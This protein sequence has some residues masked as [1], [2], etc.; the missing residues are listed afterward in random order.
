[1]A[2]EG[3]FHPRNGKTKEKK[4]RKK[5]KKIKKNKR[6]ERNEKGRKGRKCTCA[7]NPKIH[8]LAETKVLQ[9]NMNTTWTTISKP[10]RSRRLGAFRGGRCTALS[11]TPKTTGACAVSG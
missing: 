8:F 9:S 2:W 10:L 6:K 1:M 11:G 7:F 3:H 5:N 4:R